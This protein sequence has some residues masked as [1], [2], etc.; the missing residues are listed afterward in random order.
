[1]PVSANHNGT[2]RINWD[3][4]AQILIFLALVGLTAL[5]LRP[6]QR[7]L[8]NGMAR[9]RDELINKAANLI[10]REIRYSSIR[11]SIFGAFD[12]RNLRILEKTAGQDGAEETVFSVSRLRLSYSLWELLQGRPQSIHEIRFD[13]PALNLD[14]ERD[15]DLLEL[16]AREPQPAGAVPLSVRDL[17]KLLPEQARFTVRG[18]DFNVRN[19][20]A[21]YRIQQANLDVRSS[22]G[23]ISLGGRWNAAF[24]LAGLFDRSLGLRAGMRVSGSC[25]SNLEEGGAVFTITSLSGGEYTAL[26]L[27]QGTVQ[28]ELFRTRPVAFGCTLKNGVISITKLSDR[29]PV[30]FTVDYGIDSQKLSA[31][32]NCD[33]FR[34]GDFIS[35]SGDWARGNRRLEQTSSGSA[36]CELDS[37]G[38]LYY[39]I[40]LSGSGPALQGGEGDSFAIRVD[41]N[42]KRA[43]IHEL[44]F[45]SP[46]NGSAAPAFFRGAFGFRGN[47]GLSPIAPNGTLFFDNL[48]FSGAGGLSAELSVTAHENEINIF[49]DTV[50][51]G[52]TE[53][54]A[55]DIS[56]FL[57]GDDTDFQASALRFT[58]LGYNDVRLGSFSLEGSLNSGENQ[59]RQLEAS[60]RLDSFS[61]A[62]I[63]GMTG[64]FIKEAE[65]PAF[66]RGIARDT[67]ITTEVF[68]TTDFAHVLYN[69]PRF[70]VA[71]EDSSGGNG[72][73][74]GMVSVS[75]TDQRF[76]LSEGRLI[77]AD[78]ALLVSGYADYSNPQDMS[79]SL[80]AN[81][82][83][84]SWYVEGQYIDRGTLSVQGSYGL[85]AWLAA[86]GN[87]ALSGYIEADEFPIPAFRRDEG[88][89]P[90]RL[91]VYAS[92]R[93]DSPESWSLD[94]DT[95][96]TQD[97]PG[98]AGQ[99]HLRIAGRADQNGAR[100]PVLYYEDRIG[101][102][103][104]SAD[105]SWNGDFSGFSGALVMEGAA[106]RERYAVEGSY[107]E[108]KLDIALTALGMRLD[109]VL[110]NAANA[111]V[112]GSLSLAWNSPRS[113][114]AELRLESLNARVGE[115]NL[116][117]S[118]AANLDSDEFAIRDLSLNIVGIESR[119]PALRISRLRSAAETSAAFQG[120]A[121]G[122]W[123]E[124][125][126]GISAQ[127]KPIESWLQIGDALNS[128][129]GSLR[130][131]KL[132]YARTE[133]PEPFSVVFA[134]NNGAFS[135]SGGPRNMFRLNLDRDGS[136][137]AGL[138][139]PFPVRGSFTGSIRNNAIDAHCQ[140]LYVDLAAL[141]AL[142]PPVPDIALA[143]GFVKAQVD[144][145]GS[146]QDPEFFGSAQGTSVNIQVPHFIAA[147]IRPVPFTVD[148]DGNEMRF[149]PVPA[150]VGGG[151]GTASGWFRFDRWIPNIFSMTIEVPRETAI[152]F[153]FD[154]T[155]FLAHGDASGKLVLSMEDLVFDISGD[156]FANNTEMGLN[157]DEIARAQGADLFALSLVPVTVDLKVTTG[158]T[159]EFFW[160]N[161]TLPIIRANPVMGT[162]V[163]I[164]ADSLT[165]QF[166]LNSDIK[167]RSGEIFYFE[168]SFYIRSGNLVF[169]ENEQQFNPMLT[170]RAEVRDR[171][172][173]G[174]VTIALIVDNAPLLSFEPRFES[175]PSLS[176]VEIFSLLGQNITGAQEG[177]SPEAAQRVLLAS[178]TDL[179]AQFV[180]VRQAERQIRNLLRLDMFSVRT[181]VLQN[182]FFSAAGATPVDRN[183]R[184]GN[185][186]DNTTVF[187]GKYIGSDMFVQGMVSMRY[188]ENQ[189]SFGGLRF[190]P[191][192]GV[193][194]QTP[195]FNIRW[196]F[197]PQH[198]ENWWVNDNSITLTW[199]KS[200]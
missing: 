58:D 142:L 24:S 52:Q 50:A 62:D 68:F 67:S 147:D 35:L 123:L 137:Y 129:S 172:D 167:I 153:S 183:N 141:W 112:D 100:F 10:D 63:A 132:I 168:R 118:G 27:Q 33:A 116:R 162:T 2:Q 56:F 154:I 53:L 139:A 155:G 51:A 11:P 164:S 34:L 5:V 182:A 181:Q 71:Y 114:Q 199:S 44:R 149:G 23:R 110:Y 96:E 84:L 46:Q 3:I 169:K 40:D 190:E 82:R 49:G 41:G 17:A 150:S 120:Y 106:G 75:G 79:F 135:A 8:H 115:L 18:G 194:L 102:L 90:A 185:Y 109:R 166:S 19:D 125:A 64:P 77:W 177:E 189:L 124:G 15:R 136:F 74:V 133:T 171:I 7:G 107:T 151:A 148:I 175:S 130:V 99:G 197:I 157:P 192:I 184:V 93:Y 25:A 57:S 158:P 76:E 174:P 61:A 59:K 13:R 173:E 108:K 73:M 163:Q 113:F 198:P 188:D 128:V 28:D 30:A 86:S 131:E 159:V 31:A 83:D 66:L 179:L 22:D 105:I 143:G 45:S 26:S 122:R 111:A 101:P 29:L 20:A 6:L 94:V 87:G 36:L 14:M 21:F 117:A 72:G 43:A 88:F 196:D 138:S 4:F 186:F 89:A 200:F 193:E 98:P 80:M 95:L 54:T 165:R 70:V 32:L 178:T 91:T 121:A 156:L 145:R 152:P 60:L 1:V 146:L 126:F 38:R 65:L 37:A 48:S 161:A 97:I 134:R 92:G 39:R 16:L 170:A 176:Q 119:I 140:D 78:N 69:A 180:V 104:G 160:P 9:I 127:W 187:G 103:S 55:L 85:R 47:V 42:E 81:Y 144:I 12:I 195:L 191:D